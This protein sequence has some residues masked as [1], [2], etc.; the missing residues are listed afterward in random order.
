MTR[1]EVKGIDR[2]PMM[3]RWLAHTSQG[4]DLL[5]A[6][7]GI[8][9]YR[10]DLT[11]TRP[12]GRM[13]VFDGRERQRIFGEAQEGFPRHHIRLYQPDSIGTTSPNLSVERPPRMDDI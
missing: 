12:S 3:V 4:H 5:K 11:G 10:V 7:Q 6:R 8:L 9:Q 1:D 13:V 2:R